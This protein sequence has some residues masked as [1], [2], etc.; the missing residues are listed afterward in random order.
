[1]DSQKQQLLIEY[2]I[3]SPDTFALSSPI[4][5]PDYFDPE[6]RH[7]ISFLHNYYDE[8]HTLPDID[9]VEVETGK[10]FKRRNI[11][12][13]KIEY[14]LNEI[15]LFCQNMAMKNAILTAAELYEKGGDKG[16]I[17]KIVTEA[18]TVSLH[19]DMGVNFFEDPETR[20]KELM[21]KEIVEPT[22]WKEFDDLLEGGI[23][24]KQLLLFSANSG[25]G[26]SIVMANLGLNFV[27]KGFTVL[28]ISLELSQDMVDMRYVQMVTGMKAAEWQKNINR[29]A[30]TILQTK[31]KA[32]KGELYIK[33]M[34][35]GANS[36][37]IRS[38]L[39][40]FELRHGKVPDMIIVDYI[41][42]MGANEKIDLSDTFTKDKMASEELREIGEDY[43]A[44]MVSA[45]QQ[46]RGAVKAEHLDHSHIAGGI[47]KIN[48]SDVYASIILTEAMRAKGEIMFQFL[49]TRSSGGV[50]KFVHLK[51]NGVSLRI[52]NL[53]DISLDN[54]KDDSNDKPDKES[55]ED[56]DGL[57]NLSSFFSN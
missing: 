6:F 51:F 46:N 34:R 26:K 25:G 32:D 55:S 36:N 15:E 4:V 35:Q 14:C 47:S 21:K 5:K 9:Q 30:E 45:A 29:S 38:Y 28:L 24:R 22:G 50:H 43:N 39:K 41:D 2:L 33:R 13:D 10:H 7:T 54:F 23:A 19:R 49:K 48:T 53:D 56:D 20:L 3:S 11:T 16:K 40:E 27:M 37:E 1:M 18:A 42:V 31:N 52:S 44:F 8:Y 12:N 17:R 57:L